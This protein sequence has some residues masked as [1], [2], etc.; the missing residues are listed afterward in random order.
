MA[1][2]IPC[3]ERRCP[4]RAPAASRSTPRKCWLNRWD[5]SSPQGSRQRGAAACRD[6][7]G[8]GRGD[9]AAARNELAAPSANGPSTDPK[10]TVV[11]VDPPN[12]VNLPI[13]TLRTEIGSAA[14][15]RS[16]AWAFGVSALVVGR[17]AVIGS[18]FWLG[19][20]KS[21]PSKPPPSIAEA[22]GQPKVQPRGTPERRDS[23]T[24][25]RPLRETARSRQ[26]ARPPVPKSEQPT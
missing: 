18:I 23:S 2:N 21:E 17:A 6:C 1:E 11:A 22:R 15:R 10:E 25:R 20:I 9:G 26:K 14:G 4:P 8:V 16:G 7:G 3:S 19:Q 12:R 24:P 5:W 13:P